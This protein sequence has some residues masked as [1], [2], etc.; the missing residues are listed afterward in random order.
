MA[1]I[2]IYNLD[3]LVCAKHIA[4]E[5]GVS[6]SHRDKNETQGV[7]QL[8]LGKGNLWLRYIL[9]WKHWKDLQT[10]HVTLTKDIRGI[11]MWNQQSKV[12]IHAEYGIV[13]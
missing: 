7:L 13:Q 1:M 9:I 4:A 6:I 11:I 8:K 5:C 12:A 2:N 10:E 3:K